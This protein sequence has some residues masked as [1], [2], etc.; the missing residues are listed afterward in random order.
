MACR[1]AGS[2]RNTA[3]ESVSD[4]PGLK[5]LRD[6]TLVYLDQ[7]PVIRL[8]IAYPMAWSRV[9]HPT[10]MLRKGKGAILE[11]IEFALCQESQLLRMFPKVIADAIRSV[12]DSIRDDDL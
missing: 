8:E 4:K 7:V 10:R 5:Q 11:D 2:S 6:S 3:D 12:K 9:G 1:S